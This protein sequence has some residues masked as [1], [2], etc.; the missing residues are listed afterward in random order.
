[1]IEIKHLS[2]AE[3]NIRNIMQRN[4][5]DEKDRREMLEQVGEYLKFLCGVQAHRH[6]IRLAYFTAA[7]EVYNYLRVNRQLRQDVVGVDPVVRE[8]IEMVLSKLL[9]ENGSR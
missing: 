1:M 3:V 6:T 5:R 2:V 8:A 9:A 4:F 7:Y